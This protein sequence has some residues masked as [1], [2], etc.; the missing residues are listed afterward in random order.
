VWLVVITFF[1]VCYART[2]SSF[3]SMFW[4]GYWFELYEVNNIILS[5]DKPVIN[6]HSR[7]EKL[8]QH[9]ETI[10]SQD[11]YQ[12]TTKD[13][14]L[15]PYTYIKKQTSDILYKEISKELLQDEEDKK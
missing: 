12:Y 4:S 1:G 9:N 14:N 2:L 5:F 3:W 13:I 7:S 8:W 10:L 11:D 15:D 6:V